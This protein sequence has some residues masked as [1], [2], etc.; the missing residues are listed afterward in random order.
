MAPGSMSGQIARWDWLVR[1][2]HWWVA[3]VFLWNYWWPDD[4]DDLHQWLGYSLLAVL[5]IRWGWGFVG[6]RNAR[7]AD[8]FPTPARVCNS[9]H[10]FRAEHQAEGHKPHH[11]PLAGVM[12]VGLWLGLLVTGFSGWLQETDR[13]WGEQWVQLL[14]EW[15]A[16]LVMAAVVVHIAAVV[17][18]QWR[19]KL[20]LVKAML[21]GRS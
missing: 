9:I 8:F 6:P 15:S 10:H 20:P 2:T 12:V 16:N 5:V 21:F 14:H 4:G 13:Y 17:W 3:A 7:W 1:L 18:I 19:F 11:T